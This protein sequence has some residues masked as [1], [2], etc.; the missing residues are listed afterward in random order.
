VLLEP[1]T[2]RGGDAG[3]AAPTAVLWRARKEGV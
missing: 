2:V 3:P 1:P